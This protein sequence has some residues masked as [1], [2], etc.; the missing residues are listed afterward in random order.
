MS[1]VPTAS[2]I[3]NYK[4]RYP[5]LYPK[6]TR[7]IVLGILAACLLGY[8]LFFNSFVRG[9]DAL[10]AGNYAEALRLLEPLAKGGMAPAQTAL[11]MM[12][13]RGDGVQ[14]DKAIAA[15]YYRKAAEQGFALAQV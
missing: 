14:R 1:E 5:S 2:E 10:I 7:W 9:R 4:A 6:R 13:D 15:D 12:Y 11:G 8:W 3:I